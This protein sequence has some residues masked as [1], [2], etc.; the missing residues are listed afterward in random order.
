MPPLELEPGTI[1]V[2][3]RCTADRHPATRVHR[4]ESLQTLHYSLSLLVFI[5]S[6]RGILTGTALN[7]LAATLS[8]ASE[9]AVVKLPSR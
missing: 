3:I 7:N 1:L 2:L 9:G 4:E 6:L 8:E 5:L